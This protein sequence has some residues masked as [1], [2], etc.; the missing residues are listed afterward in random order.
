[1]A[2]E[3]RWGG[4]R[5][6]GPDPAGLRSDQGSEGTADA[7][8][9]R[10]DPDQV[11]LDDAAPPRRPSGDDGSALVDRRRGWAAF[12]RVWVAHSV[13]SLGDQL[14]L[15]ALPL[16]TFAATDS[17]VAVGVVASAEAVTAVAFGLLAGALADRL[18][19][20]RV[21]VRTDLLRAVVLALLAIALL[22][23]V[24][25][26]P[27]LLLAAVVVGVVRVAHDASAGAVVPILVTDAD[28][29]AANG[30]LQGSD[31]A[32]T[33]TGPA[34][35]GGLIAVGG[36][37]LAFAADAVTFLASAGAIRT[38]RA[39][40][41]AP[42]AVPAP[43]PHLWP[44]VT[45]GLRA[46]LAD[47]PMVR[48]VAVGAA[49]NV[50]SVCLE[51]QF[52]PYADRVLGIGA[53]GIGALFAVGGV[54]AVLTS[55]LVATRIRARGDVIVAAVAVYALG[56][57]LAGALP[58]LVTAAIAFVAAG[59]GSALVATHLASLR[60]RRFSIRLQGRVAMAIRTLVLGL[61]PLPLVGGGYLSSA[62]GPEALFLV[63]AAV[64][65]VVVVWAV[66]SG[67]TQV[68]AG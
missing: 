8:P 45:E 13:S 12:R 14:T 54:S 20:R 38:V 34:L 11:R 31:S 59:A 5:P 53:L 10:I 55:A 42:P 56:V 16:A 44:A 27:A 51:A 28:L 24:P 52:I 33:A 26:L 66:A 9:L 58:S 3:D 46:L 64:A 32:A 43:A 7:H 67:A 57:G 30:R 29:L 40:D 39:L 17:A 36:P 15:V 1:M 47:P 25:D 68:R 6:A 62:A 61:L 22:T 63:A 65:A 4:D 41:T 18:P 35:A 37:A 49:L 2:A 60:Q 21:L 50:M 23:R 48:L 19:H